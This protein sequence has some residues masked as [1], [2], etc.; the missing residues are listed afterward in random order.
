MIILRKNYK[1]N[2]IMK[3]N[4]K[5][6]IGALIVI[7]ILVAGVFIFSR[8]Q[9]GKQVVDSTSPTDQIL[10]TVDSSVL[11]SLTA[12]SGNKELLLKA[13]NIP[14]GTQSVD[15][16]L[17]Y[18]TAQQ[19]LQG[20]IGTVSSEGSSFEKKLT[21]GTCS[22]GTCVYHQVVGKIKLT[23]KFTGDY[24]EKLFEKEYEL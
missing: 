2:F 18:Q 17:S 13:S 19:G 12:Q 10:P 6:Y 14:S 1:F 22:S 11:V 15:Y 8:K 4:K 24:G 5:F 9:A 20:V 3:L 16:E 7:V 23:L 21:L